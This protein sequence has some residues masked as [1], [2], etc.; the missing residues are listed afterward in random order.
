[1]NNNMSGNHRNRAI[2]LDLDDPVART[3][4]KNVLVEHG[5]EDLIDMVGVLNPI[6]FYRK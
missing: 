4:A 5:A 1:M 2:K 6:P 3:K